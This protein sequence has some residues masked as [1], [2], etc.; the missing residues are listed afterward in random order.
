MSEI[1]HLEQWSYEMADQIQDYEDREMAVA[2]VPE[3]VAVICWVL[4]ALGNDDSPKTQAVL[5]SI[6][7]RRSERLAKAKQQLDSWVALS[8]S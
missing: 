5:D 3:R 4:R 1:S 6:A 7:A 8:K 2:I